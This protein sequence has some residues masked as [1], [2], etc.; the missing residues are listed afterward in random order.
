MKISDLNPHIRYARVHKTYYHMRKYIS[1]CYDCRVFFFDN[2]T[3]NVVV[4]GN[5]YNILNKTAIYFPPATEYKFNIDFKENA[6]IIVLDFDLTNKYSH[7]KSA[8]GTA[9]KSNFDASHVLKYPIAEELSKPIIRLIPQID[10]MLMQCTDDFILKNH[11]YRENS[12]ALLKLCLLEFI[13]QNRKNAH[14]NL[15]E[16]VLSY[17]HEN[18]SDAS[19]TN[20]EI[21]TKFNYHPYHLSRVIKEETGKT[22]HKYITY[23]RIQIAKD[24]L[25]TT[26]YDISEIAW[27]SGFCSSAYFIK[28]FRQNVGMTPKEYRRLH[29]HTEI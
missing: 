28:T 13:R 15:C 11:L 4:N 7:L 26:Q 14:S 27:R 23:Y 25:L 10:R 9:T 8:L 17:I 1:I 29:I 18:Y 2:I 24:F 22:L 6:K 3:G 12:S 19:L 20:E 16:S 21:A 5:K